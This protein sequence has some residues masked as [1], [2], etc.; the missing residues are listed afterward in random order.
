MQNKLEATIIF[1]DFSKAFDSIHKG[2]MEQIL[3]AYSL[4]NLFII[5]LEYMLRTSIDLMKDNGFKQ[6]MERS[7]RYPA[8]PITNVNYAD[9]IALLANIPAQAE[10][11]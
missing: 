11:L 5:C 3:H 8:Q 6:A 2:K 1:V 10:T 4:P 9:D 7:R